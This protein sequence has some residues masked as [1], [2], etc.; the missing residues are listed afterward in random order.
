M[1]TNREVTFAVRRLV[2]LIRR[3]A[4]GGLGVE[5]HITPMQGRVIGY[6]THHAPEPVYQR[7]LEREFQ[8]RRSTASAILQTMEKSGLIRREP[9]PTD[10]RLKRIVLTGRAEAFHENFRR[11]IARA[12][13]VIVDGVDPKEMETFFR[14]VDCF[15]KNLNDYIAQRGAE[16]RPHGCGEE[17]T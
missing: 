17:C 9:V 11:E 5:G 13:A 3:L 10:A 14:V 16:P 2:N 1:E 8:V 12:E 6:V 7:D 15:A 4:E